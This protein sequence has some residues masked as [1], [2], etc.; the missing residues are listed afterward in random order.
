MTAGASAPEILV[1]E[2]VAALRHGGATVREVKAVEESVRFAVPA[3]LEQLA[4]ERGIMLPERT[5]MRQ[6]I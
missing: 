3:E 4:K 1:T 2:V 6:S 5:A